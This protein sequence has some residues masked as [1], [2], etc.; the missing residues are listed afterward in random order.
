MNKPNGPQDN[1][2]LLLILQEHWMV[3]LLPF[4]LYLVGLAL[5]IFLFWLG[6]N[7]HELAHPAAMVVIF[8]SYGVV[9]VAHHWLFLYLISFQ[10]SGLAVTPSRVI[11]F[12]FFPYVRHDMAYINIREINEIEKHQHGLIKNLLHYGE[13]ELNLSANHRT[14]EF[15]FVPYPG[16][17]VD[18]V[19]RLSKGN[20]THGEATMI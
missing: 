14:V 12:R 15:K 18:L 17:L 5:G 11:D 8:I 6:N 9:L 4:S 3:F 1:E 13:V 19:S 10:V 16:R 20:N 7:L 2:P